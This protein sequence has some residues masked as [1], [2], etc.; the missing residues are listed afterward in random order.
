MDN[1]LVFAFVALTVLVVRAVL[2]ELETIDLRIDFS[3]KTLRRGGTKKKPYV[4]GSPSDE[5]KRLPGS[6][7]TR[8]PSD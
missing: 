7:R 2:S 5:P 1:G 8:G 3:K 6:R 4:D